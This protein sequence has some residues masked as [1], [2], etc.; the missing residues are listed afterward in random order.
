M[1]D[2]LHVAVSGTGKRVANAALAALHDQFVNG[3]AMSRLYVRL[4]S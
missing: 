1:N 4:T 2:S 3:E